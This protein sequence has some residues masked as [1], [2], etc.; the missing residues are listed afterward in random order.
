MGGAILFLTLLMMLFWIYI[1]LTIDKKRYDIMIW[2]LDIPIPYVAHL[3]TQCD[4]YLKQ[5]IGI[6]ELQKKGAPLDDEEDYLEEYTNKKN[7]PNAN[8]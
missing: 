7:G 4:L 5:F 1:L 6:K 3:G 8:D 2:F